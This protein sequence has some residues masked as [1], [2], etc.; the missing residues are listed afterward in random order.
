MDT[1]TVPIYLAVGNDRQFM[2]MCELLDAPALAADPRYGSNAS[3][4][5]HRDTLMPSLRELLARHDGQAL[6]VRLMDAGV[7]CAP[8]LNVGE[9]MHHPQ[10]SHRNRIVDLAGER[11]IASPITLRRTPATYRLLPPTDLQPLA[12]T[13]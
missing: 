1:A 10:T 12:Q 5:E 2:R 11:S 4:S 3:R 7:P 13:R 6:A 8:V 9:V